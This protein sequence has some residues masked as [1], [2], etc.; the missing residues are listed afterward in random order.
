MSNN[1]SDLTVGKEIRFAVIMYGGVSLAIYINGVAQE[2]LKMCRATDGKRK[3]DDLKS[4]EM[5]YRQIAYLLADERRLND[6]AEFLS[7]SKITDDRERAKEQAKREREARKIFNDFIK[8]DPVDLARLVVD[9]LTGTSA[10]GINAIFLAKALANNQ[11]MDQLKELWL[12]EG[13]IGIL[14]N[15]KYSI[16]GTLLRQDGKAKSLLNSHRMYLKLLEAFDGMTPDLKPGET[17]P[18]VEDLDLFVPTTDFE[19][20]IVPLR[21]LDDVV[22][23]KRFRQ[24]FHFRYQANAINDFESK[25]N[26]MLA[27]AARATSSFP[28]AFEPMRLSQAEKIINDV[29]PDAARRTAELKAASE[30]FF[31]KIVQKNGQI[32]EW[33]E[34]DLVDGGVLDNKPFGYAIDVLSKRR[35]DF[36]VERKLLYIE[37]SPESFSKNN[38]SNQAPDVL[39]N[40]AAS[41]SAIP[42]YETI[43]EDLER[44]LER[45]K[46]IERVNRLITGAENDVFEFLTAFGNVE[47]MPSAKTD[48]ESKGLEDI[49]NLKG[50]NVLPYY[51]LRIAELTDELAK[52]VARMIGVS[53]D[54]EYFQTIRTLVR[55]WR[56]DQF[57]NYSGVKKADGTDKPT[58]MAFLGKFDLNYRLR[59]L[60][61]VQQKANALY[62]FNAVFEEEFKKR[63]ETLAKLV[64]RRQQKARSNVK[65]KKDTAKLEEAEKTESQKLEEH[66]FIEKSL[67]VSESYF[68][69]MEQTGKSENLPV[70]SDEEGENPKTVKVKP[71]EI[72]WSVFQQKEEG[73]KISGREQ[74]RLAAGYF[75]KQ[76]KT[77]YKILLKQ[78]EDLLFESNA[79]SNVLKNINIS[80]EELAKLQSKI[81]LQT[82]FDVSDLTDEKMLESLKNEFPGLFSQIEGA[83]AQLQIVFSITFKSA[84][85]YVDVLL[86]EEFTQ[87]PTELQDKGVDLTLLNAV[88]GY[89][90]NYYANFDDY[91]QISFPIYYQTLIG[92]AVKVDVM[93]ISPQDAKLLNGKLDRKKVAGEK[94][95]HF[96]AFLD[97]VWRKNDIMW[98]RLDGAE[99]LITALLPDKKY[100]KLREF[101][102]KQAHEI[103]LK[104]ELLEANKEEL[105]GELAKSLIQVSAGLPLRDVIGKVTRNVDD[106]AVKNR[107]NAILATLFDGEIGDDKTESQIYEYVKNYYHYEEKLEPKDLL[108]VVSRSTKVTGDIFEGIAEE[109]AQ[110]GSRL[111]WIA[112][113]GQVFWG[114]VEVAA[115]GSFFNMLFT[116]WLYILY[117]FEVVL[118][119]GSTIFVKPETQQFG[120][121][122]LI[123][124]LIIHLT[125]TALYDYMKGGELWVLFKFIAFGLFSLLTVLGG[126][127]VYAFFY[128]MKFWGHL[129]DLQQGLM[130]WGVFLQLLPLVLLLGLFAVTFGVRGYR[131]YKEAAKK[132]NS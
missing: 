83:A 106:E 19:G 68:E 102:T 112:R 81:E 13:D 76:L 65:N 69:Q 24:V 107:L 120:I 11:E 15:D 30:K 55:T 84:R 56:D 28:F 27:V 108:K 94:L 40:A 37:P 124:T 36:Q 132:R 127:F 86:S 121:V 39:Q 44:L 16:D 110:A 109:K 51:R 98:G 1:D 93:R 130:N 66:P 47:N 126:L 117:L 80:N 89:L 92:E 57:N 70:E 125:A 7:A 64:E 18:F 6:W 20:T 60:R 101:F 46:L 42:S 82:D 88:R 122:S 26:A 131:K 41:L 58:T 43:R 38:N 79:V 75:Q 71:T 22:E 111:R 123:L 99:R 50:R 45:N 104:N 53:E 100:E 25:N 34:R 12:N 78:R 10:G 67:T 113:L 21:L 129:N 49:V 85:G 48:W 91:D 74:I 116:H 118:I 73:T 90:E 29:F 72:I 3:Y 5:V 9:I 95:F 128:D 103:I 17:S 119:I 2:L 97:R 62:D 96:G 23:E 61:M 32:I 52:L 87:L 77:I 14:I 54:S 63:Q 105:R 115:P 33:K 31:P 35:A 59:R 8:N 114:L 4:D